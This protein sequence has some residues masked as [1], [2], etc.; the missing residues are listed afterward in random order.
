MYGVERMAVC[1]QWVI[2]ELVSRSRDEVNLGRGRVGGTSHEASTPPLAV[3]GGS[4]H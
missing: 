1:R 2:T 4:A 3:G